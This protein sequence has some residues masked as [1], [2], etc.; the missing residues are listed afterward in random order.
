MLYDLCVIASF[1]MYLQ[2]VYFTF[3]ISI[4][5]KCICVMLCVFTIMLPNLNSFMYTPCS[6]CTM[7]IRVFMCILYMCIQFIPYICSCIT[8]IHMSSC[9]HKYDSWI[10]YYS[11]LTCIHVFYASNIFKCMLYSPHILVC[12]IQLHNG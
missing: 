3:L 8:C 11:C 5:I 7:C 10:M 4:D 6:L 12:M 1:I 9:I 2:Y